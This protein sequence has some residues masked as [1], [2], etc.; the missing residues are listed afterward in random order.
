M[1]QPEPS[2]ARA[3]IVGVGDYSHLE[4]LPAVA[5]NVR[6]LAE[7]LLDPGLWGLADEHC[8]VLLNPTSEREVLEAVHQ[9]AS[10]AEE[11]FLFYFAGHGL[12]EPPD[13]LHLALPDASMERL[14]RALAYERLRSLILTACK[15]RHKVVILDTCFSGRALKGVMAP[16]DVADI[17]GVDGT[18]LMTSSAENRRSMAPVGAQYTL[19]TGEL[20]AVLERGDPDVGDLL[21]MHTVYR[22]IE[23]ALRAGGGPTPQQRAR[24]GG[25]Q[26]ALVRN[27]AH[28]GF[29]HRPVSGP[30]TAVLQPGHETLLH[31]TVSGFVQRL[32]QLVKSG[33]DVQADAALVAVATRWP[34]QQTASLLGEFF[35]AG[36]TREA[37][38]ACRIVADRPARE[39]AGC[40]DVLDRLGALTAVDALV[41]ALAQTG[42]S[43]VAPVAR[44]LR[45]LVPALTE[46]LIRAAFAEA[47]PD[48]AADL[49]D[50]LYRCALGEEALNALHGVLA[51]DHDPAYLR[52]ADTLLALG[53]NAPAYEIYRA[54]P[55]AL[56]ASRPREETA[57]LLSSMADHGAHLLAEALLADLLGAGDPAERVGWALVLGAEGLDWADE[58]ARGLLCSAAAEDVLRILEHIRRTRPADLL[59]VVRWAIGED[60]SAAD[61]VSF[62]MAL[63]EYGL[64]LDA[65]RILDEAAD[66]GPETA[67]ILIST[68]SAERGS[69]ASRLVRRM[70]D[71][72]LTD[73]L[74]L[75]ALL[76]GYGGED[77]AARMLADVLDRPAEQLLDA[78]LPL[79]GEVGVE[80][81]YSCIAP[82]ARGSQVAPVLLGYWQSGRDT[83]A[84]QL[85][86]LLAGRE[87]PLLE[88]TLS[89]APLVLASELRLES[90]AERGR[91]LGVSETRFVQERWAEPLAAAVPRLDSRTLLRVV[92]LAAEGALLGGDWGRWVTRAL[93]SAVREGLLRMRVS[94]VLALIA[95]LREQRSGV[96]AQAPATG[97][98]L[99]GRSTLGTGGTQPLAWVLESALADR[100]DAALLLSELSEAPGYA[101]RVAGELRQVLR[102]APP[103]RAASVYWIMVRNGHP[104]DASMLSEIAGRPDVLDR[105]CES[106]L[107]R[108]DA[109]RIRRAGQVPAPQRRSQAVADVLENARGVYTASVLLE[110]G[111][112]LPRQQL[113]E[114]LASFDERAGRYEA[115]RVI[116]GAALRP[117]ALRDW[118]PDVL[119]V[120]G[121]ANRDAVALRLVHRVVRRSPVREVADTAEDL[122]AD[123]MPEQAAMLE[124][125]NQRKRMTRWLHR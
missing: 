64:P 70:S 58:A 112:V 111:T 91:L 77:D 102:T 84:D 56:G 109:M 39:V 83:E 57:R 78:L 25:A 53:S 119:A 72:P 24:N 117:G 21:D 97:H 80:T 41:G 8:R 73:R 60:R 35:D 86:R 45:E 94:A 120:L 113:A 71:R 118:L 2:A 18:F 28:V 99:S 9:M 29:R 96:P 34:E 40:L 20:L 10:E 106:G 69:D 100:E 87:S 33:E 37:A 15:A 13:G 63:R 123:G 1:A 88:E 65:M 22:R 42:A 125:L 110:A 36:L 89:A 74:E 27:R 108:G 47:G 59:L 12:P 38:L 16:T 6:R 32:A 101:D 52:A 95:V 43:T 115:D 121:G 82:S 51:D 90:E 61:I 98:I 14:Y 104:P 4:P 67:A 68:L 55:M 79:A 31:E 49:V 85:L 48:G 62:T 122:R 124:E 76:R 93:R 26:I 50:A 81:L 7:L 107:S 116:A 105:L 17:A 46:R 30:G 54:L 11:A 92:T 114:L 3:V 23:G 19:F 103:D 75:V 66:S 44:N 5:N